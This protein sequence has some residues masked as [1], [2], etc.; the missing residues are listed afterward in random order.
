MKIIKP[1]FNW[2][3]LMNHFDR[4]ELVTFRSNGNTCT[5]SVWGQEESEELPC[6]TDELMLRALQ[7]EH[8]FVYIKSGEIRIVKAWL[9]NGSF[10]IDYQEFLLLTKLSLDICE[11]SNSTNSYLSIFSKNMINNKQ[12][13]KTALLRAWKDS[14]GV[15]IGAG[16][17]KEMIEVST[18]EGLL[19]QFDLNLESLIDGN[20]KGTNDIL[21]AGKYLGRILRPFRY[22]TFD[23]PQISQL[24]VDPDEYDGFSL[25]SRDYATK[26][27]LITEVGD[28]V[29]VTILTEN[30]LI[31]G[32]GEI[33]N[34]KDDA[35]VFGD[36]YKHQV[37]GAH[38][39]GFEKLK[40]SEDVYLDIQTI[41]NIPQ[42]REKIPQWID[43]M[44]TDVLGD[45]RDGNLPVFMS[46]IDEMDF[47]KDG[48]LARERWVLKRLV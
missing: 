12:W 13:N 27:G 25:I 16:A 24:D 31:K 41:I 6:Q 43:Y 39:S 2:I 40:K 47:Q 3:K 37:K 23:Q 11:E 32:H 17:N 7:E 36:Q 20:I 35:V 19:P 4:V 5:R 42:L 45:I 9:K 28:R 21:K 22:S 38:F 48:T 15:G 14:Q 29:E 18:H 34:I 44:L 33:R 8:S 30:G 1:Q 10:V 26:C 46:R